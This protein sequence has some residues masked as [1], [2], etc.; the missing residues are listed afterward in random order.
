MVRWLR[1]GWALPAAA[2]ISGC[3]PEIGDKCTV[4]TDCS[5]LG[6]RL[7][8]ATQP[9]GYCTIFNC[10]PDTC[11]ESV[12]VSFDP[13][14]DP[15][16]READ[17]S[18]WARFERT[19]CMAPCEED[20]DCRDGYRC[21][22]LVKDPDLDLHPAKIV[23]Q[24]RI[25]DKVCLVAA[26]GATASEVDGGIPGVCNP[27]DA[28]APWTPYDAAGGTGAGGAGGSGGAGGGV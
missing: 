27:A 25:S 23:D 18:Q 12:C 1:L 14:L 28:G 8:D 26:T 11:P 15:A 10:E 21:V 5:Q 13:D 24:R 3:T 2:L 9:D 19:F 7:C 6:D 16:C 22:D 17:D 4:S 20:G